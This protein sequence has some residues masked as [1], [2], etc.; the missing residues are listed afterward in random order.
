MNRKRFLRDLWLNRVL[1]SAL[2]PRAARWRLLRRS[3]MDIQGWCAIMPGCWFG[4]TSLSIGRDSTVNYG[5]FFDTSAPIS[6]GERCD[7]GMQVM[8][9]TGTHRIGEVGR[10]AGTSVSQPIRI[11]SGTWIG[12]R[13]VILPGVTVGQGCVIAAGAVVTRDCA[14]NTVYAGV[15]A[16]AV[17][18][19]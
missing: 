8:F 9:C 4:G 18:T 3:G 11:G 14:D 15:P 5:V 19:L 16:R 12:T 17:R 13:A 6:I 2:L 1:S 10:R 7:I